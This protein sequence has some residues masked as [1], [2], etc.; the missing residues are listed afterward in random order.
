MGVAGAVVGDRVD[1]V[2]VDT[3]D[4]EAARDEV[5]R[6]A[7]MVRLIERGARAQKIPDADDA[8]MQFIAA[9]VP[10]RAAV[11]AALLEQD[12]PGRRAGAAA[13]ARACVEFLIGWAGDGRTVAPAP[14]VV[15]REEDLVRL[16]DAFRHREADKADAALR[17]LERYC[18]RLQA[19]ASVMETM[20]PQTWAE[21]PGKDAKKVAAKPPA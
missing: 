1:G 21:M 17:T 2:V 12:E 8:L 15:V 14:L 6:A 7:A 5:S 20:G 3:I 13:F 16:V 18:K 10:A 9:A 4:Q 19:D 11:A